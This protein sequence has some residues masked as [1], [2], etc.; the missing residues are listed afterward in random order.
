LAARHVLD[1]WDP[2]HQIESADMSPV[3]DYTALFLIIAMTLAPLGM[4]A[5]GI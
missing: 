4:A 1:S 5:Y 2:T 3:Y